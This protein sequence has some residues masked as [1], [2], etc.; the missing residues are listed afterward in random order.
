VDRHVS[1]G[2]RPA[3]G[4]TVVERGERRVRASLGYVALERLRPGPLWPRLAGRPLRPLLVPLD[5]ELPALLLGALPARRRATNDAQRP[6]P[7]AHTAVKDASLVGD[8]C[9]GC[10]CDP[11]ERDEDRARRRELSPGEPSH[12]P[13]DATRRAR[14][15]QTEAPADLVAIH[16][17]HSLLHQDRVE[18]AEDLV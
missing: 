18:R 7:L 16:H 15:T 10:I 3:D 14:R 17:L 1:I 9:D 5:R 13:V 4:Q 6:V 11:R 2:A 12:L 8:A